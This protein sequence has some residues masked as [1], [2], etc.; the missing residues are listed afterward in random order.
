MSIQTIKDAIEE[1]VK[2]AMEDRDR[3]KW[4]HDITCFNCTGIRAAVVYD[5]GSVEKE[6]IV[7]GLKP[8]LDGEWKVVEFTHMGIGDG[9]DAIDAILEANAFIQNHD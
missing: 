4:E 5:S 1:A 2:K 3:S 7:I 9:K 8:N 6:F